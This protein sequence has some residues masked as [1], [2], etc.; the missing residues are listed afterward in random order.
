MLSLSII[1]A[2]LHGEDGVRAKYTNK[3]QKASNFGNVFFCAFG[4]F[5]PL[6]LSKCLLYLEYFVA[7][8]MGC[9]SVL[10]IVVK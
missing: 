7:G 3:L 10:H 4:E 8:G 5:Q 9:L 6:F 1:F 2:V